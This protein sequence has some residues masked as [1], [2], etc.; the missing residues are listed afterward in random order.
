MTKARGTRREVPATP[1]D[2]L[3]L[4]RAE[5]RGVAPAPPTNRIEPWREKAAPIPAKRREDEQAV[6]E[7]LARLTLDGDDVEFE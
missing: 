6:L 5:M 1:A 7:E 3:A 4:F 2:D